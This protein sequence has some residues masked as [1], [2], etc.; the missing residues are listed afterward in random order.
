MSIGGAVR[1]GGRFPYRAGMTMR[2]LVLLAGGLNE[3]A[4]LTEAEIARLPASRAGGVTARTFRV[5]LDST[6]LFERERGRRYAAA[7]GLPA[8]RAARPTSCSQPYD[9]VLILRQPD[10]ALQRTVFLGGEVRYPGRYAL[11]RKTERLSEV[12]TRAGG[13][14][15]E[16]FADGVVFYRSRDST[17]RVGIDLPRVLR[18]ARSRDNFSFG[19][20]LGARPG[21]QPVVRVEGAVNAP[22]RSPSV[23][24]AERRRL[25]AR[26]RR[27][28]ANAELRRA[29]V[30]Q[31]NGK[32]QGVA[33]PVRPGRRA[34]PAPRRPRLRAGAA[35]SAPSD[36]R[37]DARD[38]RADHR[39][40]GVDFRRGGG[41]EAERTAPRGSQPT[42][43]PACRRTRRRRGRSCGSA[44]GPARGADE[45][46]DPRIAVSTR[47]VVDVLPLVG[48][49]PSWAGWAHE[50]RRSRASGRPRER[51]AETVAPDPPS[52]APTQE[53]PAVRVPLRNAVLVRRA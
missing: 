19:R 27:R 48:A 13:L 9:N 3:G 6:Y 35:A 47:S 10:F 15:T 36:M 28:G 31:P 34:G 44:P 49:A 12:I 22:A 24:G 18:D 39:D 51:S 20:R 4:L 21:V 7:R 50:R 8:P 45:S 46:P 52:P 14:T 53:L 16:G 42:R 37:G 26:R 23:P 1:G 2:D 30:R 17:G 40:R 32:V 5:P 38:R 25:R 33:T 43:A 11:R 41:R 29:Y